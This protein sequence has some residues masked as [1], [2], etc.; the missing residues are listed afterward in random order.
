[1]RTW[2]GDRFDGVIEAVRY[3]KN[4]KIEWVRAYERRGPTWSD[5]VLLQRQML[6]EKLKAGKRFYTGQRKV[7]HASEFDLGRQI[8]VAENGKGEI[9]QTDDVKAGSRDMLQGVP[10]I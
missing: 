2:F 9:I 6:L 10:V 3:R 8:V 7:L 5:H 1:M 4:G